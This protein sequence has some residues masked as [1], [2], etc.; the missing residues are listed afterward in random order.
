MSDV[1]SQL[2]KIQDFLYTLRN[3]GSKYSLE[4]IQKFCEKLGNPQN[5]FPKIHIAGTNG[6]GSVCAMIESI[7]RGAGLKVGM[8]TSPHL[9]YLGERI[10]IDRT[11]IEK[12]EL[13][14]LSL[15]LKSCAD[16]IFPKDDMAM[17]P[18]FF[19]FM[20]AM[21]FLDFSRNNVDCAVIEVGLGGRLDS[22][23]I[24]TPD[25]SVITSI[26]F[27]H[28]Q[29]L[30]ASLAEIAR[31]KGGI[32]KEKV[33]V[34]CGFL[35]DEA[36]AEIEKIAHKKNAPLY[37]VSDYFPTD[38]S[39]PTTSLFGYYQRRNG[40]V[41]LLCSRILRE[42]ASK[43]E[44]SSIY[45]ALSEKSA[46]EALAKVV[47]LARWQNIKLANGATLIVDASHNDEGAKNLESNLAELCA[48]GLRPIITVGVLGEDRAIPL[49][50]GMSKYA[51]K[52]ILLQPNQPRALSVDELKKCLGKVDVDVETAKVSDIYK[53]G[54]ICTCVEPTDT[55]ISTGSIYL[56]GEVLA[57]ISGG[58]TDG[59]QDIPYK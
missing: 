4:R 23:N 50:K 18:S 19:E 43:G 27:D 10:Q 8:F 11:P 14:K 58:G 39:L 28:V 12:D 29:M 41:S 55:I 25:I 48:D 46:K 38:E 54:K 2:E 40:A 3:A 16:S 13:S 42:H 47:W 31:E 34:V 35:P 24:I 7:L 37:K 57:C 6:K 5:D 22:T 56:A 30:G 9:T 49:L 33:P 59:L 36:M 44:V 32:I 15:E 53:S 26:G 17:Y 1:N 51:K 21:A 20:T 45:S 52:I